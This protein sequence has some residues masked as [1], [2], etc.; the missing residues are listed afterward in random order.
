[1]LALDDATRGGSEE[2]HLQACL[3]I[4]SEHMHG[5]SD[6]ARIALNRSLVIAEELGDVLNQVGL[7]GML[8]MFHFRSGDFRTALQYATRCRADAAT[9]ESPAATALAHSILG[10]TLHYMG[11]LSGARTELEALLRHWPLSQRT[12]TVYLGY[13]RHYRAAIHLA[14]TLWLQGH[15][16]Q[17]VARAQ[18]TVRDAKRLDNPTSLA[19][20]LVLAAS[21][22]LWTGDFSSAEEHIDASIALSRSHSLGP[23]I[24]VG[25]ARKGELAILRGEVNHGVE[26]LR[27]ALQKIHAVHY[28]LLTTEFNLSLVQGLAAIGQPTEALAL[29]DETIRRVETN[30][31]A[32]YMP[33]L[34]R[35]KGGLLL[36]MPRPDAGTAEACFFRSLE[37]GRS[38]GARA[39]ELRT[40][41][42]LAALFASQGRS[43][44]G[45]A[46][47][48]PVLEQFAEGSDTADL[49]AAARLLATLG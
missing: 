35:L 8:H 34:L 33:E 45:R 37:I 10:R 31:A 5:Q 49:Q 3:G 11:D 24:A 17:A 36:S 13:D 2:M 32:T 19:V 29:V 12:G 42:D 15:P 39:F 23:L 22:F 46:L 38:Q 28:E 26:G 1:M 47:L 6:A 30:G 48:Q 27:A 18:Q 40:A 4:A 7:L 16:A 44:S 14:R 41:T 9:I 20:V 21:V 43:E 25:Q